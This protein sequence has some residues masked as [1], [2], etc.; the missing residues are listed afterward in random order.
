MPVHLPALN[1]RRL[2]QVSGAS[3]LL[4]GRSSTAAEAAEV[5]TDLVYLLNDTHI[6]EQQPEE[7]PVPSRLRKVVTEL[8]NR[9]T[10]PVCVLINGDLALKDGQPGDYRLFAKLIRPLQD[11]GIETNLTLGNHDNR[12]AFF[13]VM[14]EQRAEYSPVESR[15]VAIVETEH[16]NFVLLDS[17]QKTMVTQG[18]VGTQ[19]L[20]WLASALDR[21]QSKPAIIVTHHNPRLGGDPLH[22]P[23]GLIDSEALWD[24]IGPRPWVKAYIHGHI[25]DRGYANHRGIHIL[26]MPA[27]SYVADPQKSTT[28]WTTAKL[29]ATGVTLTTHTTDEAHRWNGET[30]TLT[31]R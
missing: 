11:A 4:C 20:Q 25:H 10:K 27:T 2:L 31:W 6:G 5:E 13:G 17:L 21:F 28:G 12:E 23:G 1:R 16:A 3:M 15:H 30:K 8:V 24:V 14:K 22:F 19:Q 26:N 18:T 29:T 9:P 7:S